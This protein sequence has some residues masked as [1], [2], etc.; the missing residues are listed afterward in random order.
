MNEEFKLPVSSYD[1]IM[2]VVKAY[3][4]GKTGVSVSLDELTKVSGIGR[5]VISKN[6]GFLIQTN[7]ISKGSKKAP[8][9][10]CKKLSD[11]YSMGLSEETSKIWRSIVEQDE[12]MSKMISVVSIKKSISRQDYVKHIVFASGCGNSPTYKAGASA[13]V[14]IFKLA[15]LI[16]EDNGTISIGG[17]MITSTDMDHD[18]END[19]ARM[20]NADQNETLDEPEKKDRADESSV[21]I[22]QYTCESGQIAKIIIPGNA[23]EDDLL[24]FR[25]MLNIALKRKF[26]IKDFE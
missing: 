20:M 13:L 17:N 11:A 2:K 3:A 25:D 7:L 18:K 23:T 6:N 1:E 26:K 4:N 22:Q 14:E 24:G 21:Y 9:E 5:T 16:G 12:F 8:T 10:L 19:S 15:G